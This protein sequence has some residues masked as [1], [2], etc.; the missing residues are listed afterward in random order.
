M[1]DR[2]LSVNGQDMCQVTHD[3]AVR[4][5]MPS[6]VAEEYFLLEVRRDPSPPGLR[7]SCLSFF[8]LCLHFEMRFGSFS[9][10]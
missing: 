2:L 9:L 1:G 7:V 5:I 6:G 10:P 8:P 4:A 3:E